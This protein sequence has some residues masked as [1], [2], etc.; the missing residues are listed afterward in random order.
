VLRAL[1]ASDED[2]A[3]AAHEELAAE[4]FVFLLDLRDDEP[5]AAFIARVEKHCHGLDLPAGWVPATLL[6]AEVDGQLVGRVS[7]R[8]ELNEFLESVGGHIGYAVRPAFRRRGY[9]TEMLRQALVIAR[10]VG[11]G[12]ALLTC[13][14]DNTA[15]THVIERCGGTLENVIPGRDGTSAK[16]RYWIELTP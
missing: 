12:R 14:V 3:R 2:D 1:T 11:V 5:W 7:I 6:V 15:S 13:D 9:A 16:R 8:H 10:G 4:K